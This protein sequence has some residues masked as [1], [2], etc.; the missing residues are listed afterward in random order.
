MVDRLHSG[1]PHIGQPLTT[2]MLTFIADGLERGRA[3]IDASGNYNIKAIRTGKY[4]LPFSPPPKPESPSR[5]VQT[6]MQNIPDTSAVCKPV[7]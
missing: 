6:I 1:V 5:N 4:K 2:G 3:E 7:D